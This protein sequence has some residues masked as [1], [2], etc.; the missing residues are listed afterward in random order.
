VL[1]LFTGLGVLAGQQLDVAASGGLVGC[2]LGTI[3]GFTAVYLRY[4]EI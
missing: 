2:F 3:A 1:D 4:R